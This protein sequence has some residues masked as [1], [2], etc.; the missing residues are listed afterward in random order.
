MIIIFIVKCSSTTSIYINLREPFKVDEQ[1]GYFLSYSSVA[2][3]LER[4]H[5]TPKSGEF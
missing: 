2:K 1:L 5:T 3:A 4:S